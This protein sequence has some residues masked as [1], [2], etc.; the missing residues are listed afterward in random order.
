MLCTFLSW[1]TR[2]AIALATLA[3]V[4]G[5]LVVWSSSA[6][7]RNS[8]TVLRVISTETGPGGGADVPPQGDSVGDTDTFTS[9]M[10]DPRTGKRLGRGEAVCTIFDIAKPGGYG[11]PVRDA[12]YH[13]SFV[14]YLPGGQLIGFSSVSF[15]GQGRP[16]TRPGAILGGTG[17][18]AG[19]RG[20]AT[21]T[22][23]GEGKSLTVI[24][25]VR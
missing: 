4:A 5:A 14:G 25:L 9:V 12:T 11:P 10:S 2:L 17:R 8:P 13:C 16:H 20:W 6:P 19:A 22:P 1:R 18:Y 7:A 3:T 23:R 21:D 15:D 24:H